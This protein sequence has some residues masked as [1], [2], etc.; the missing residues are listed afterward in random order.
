MMILIATEVIKN[1]E[2]FFFFCQF[3]SNTIVYI[4][5]SLWKAIESHDDDD[6]DGDD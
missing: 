2:V 6:D 4:L 1:N 5:N 3:T